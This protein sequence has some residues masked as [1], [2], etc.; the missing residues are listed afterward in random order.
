MVVQP[1]AVALLRGEVLRRVL[2]R[3]G[4]PILLDDLVPRLLAG[5]WDDRV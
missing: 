2:A 1:A 4:K 5:E 3:A